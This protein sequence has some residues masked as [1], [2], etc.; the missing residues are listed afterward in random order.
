MKKGRSRREWHGKKEMV[1]VEEVTFGRCN[2][3]KKTPE[4]RDIWEWEN[5]YEKDNLLNWDRTQKPKKGWVICIH[6][7][8]FEHVAFEH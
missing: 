7:V 3:V 5:E 1:V 8:A 2:K 6:Y 4:E